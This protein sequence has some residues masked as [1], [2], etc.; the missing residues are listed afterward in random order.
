M[1]RYV[2]KVPDIGEGMTEA[3]IVAWHVAPGQVI[4]EEDPLVDVMTDKATV[5]LP[6]PVAGTVVAI[7]GAPGERRP[8]GSELVELDVIGEGNAV[9]KASPSQLAK[10]QQP[11]TPTL[12]PPKGRGRAAAAPQQT[13]LPE[14]VGSALQGRER[15]GEPA[16]SIL[17]AVQNRR[18]RPGEK[19]LASPAVRRRA[20]DAGIELQFVPGTGP[21]GRITQQDLDAYTQAASRPP[22]DKSDR[23]RR[24]GVEAVPIIGLRRAIAEHLQTSK[25]QIPHFSYIEEID[26]TALEELRAELNATYSDREHLTLLP[27]LLRAIVNAAAAHPQ[28]NAR[29]DDTAGVL[30]R[31]AALHIGVATQT[32]AGLLVPVVR[33]AEALDLWQTAAE[34]RRLTAAARSGKAAR[35]ELTG[36]TITV[37]SLGALGGIAATP[38]I[39]HP[40]VAIVGVNRIVERPVVHQGQIA[41]RK[42]M[43]LS[44][45]FDH[46]IVDG[47]EAASFIQRIKQLL[48]QPAMLFLG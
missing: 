4:R 33:H 46:R 22:D 29:Y 45:S 18:R 35:D 2:V 42:M 23:S 36:S 37:T 12:S 5:E 7:H 19:P 3:E 13:P 21:G 32:D 24:D 48:E 15:E 39:N 38:V 11:L 34:L 27:F 6:A 40:E 43:N 31:H 8:V 17:P 9:E 41:I 10:P 16:A 30:H 25:R 28:V 1:A 26:V 20:W 47:W 14:R 44:S